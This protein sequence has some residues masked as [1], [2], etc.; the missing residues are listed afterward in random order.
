MSAFTRPT[1]VPLQ[2]LHM[3]Q[4]CLETSVMERDLLE[5]GLAPQMLAGNK[6]HTDLDNFA[7][8]HDDEFPEGLQ[9][10]VMQVLAALRASMED[11]EVQDGIGVSGHSH[12]CT[13]PVKEKPNQP[14]VQEKHLCTDPVKEPGGQEKSKNEPL[15][16]VSD[17]SIHEQQASG[18][19]IQADGLAHKE[20]VI[21]THGLK[22]LWLM[23]FVCCVHV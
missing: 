17:S 20:K 13:D 1:H 2:Q 19:V 7:G 10:D 22:K 23:M 18:D 15:E 3:A 16:T 6:A 12:L 11:E 9:E 5:A 8:D 4:Q 14:G 21:S